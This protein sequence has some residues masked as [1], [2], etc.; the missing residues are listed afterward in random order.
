MHGHSVGGTNPS[1]LEAMGCANLIVAHDNPF[2]RETLG[3]CG[4]FFR[5]IDDLTAVIDA[6]EGGFVAADMRSA[7]QRR[8]ADIYS[9]PKIVSEYEKLLGPIR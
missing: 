2:N 8:A 3:D 5:D 7:V 6:I 1:L 4:F 9:W